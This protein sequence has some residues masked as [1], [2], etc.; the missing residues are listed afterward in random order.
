MAKIYTDPFTGDQLTRREWISWQVQ[1][2]IRRWTFLGIITTATITCWVS[3]NATVILWWNFAASYM[4]LVIESVIGLAQFSQTKRDAQI[5]REVRELLKEVRGIAERDM[6]ASEREL[7]VDLDTNI[8][9]TEAVSL[10]ED[11]A[12]ELGIEPLYGE[13]D[14]GDYE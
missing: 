13:W 8:R 6:T 12:G 14:Y 1:G 4:A 11:M 10:L 3:G 5:I 7:E 2:V 9:I